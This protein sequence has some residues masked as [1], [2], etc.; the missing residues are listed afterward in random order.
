MARRRMISAEI[1]NDEEFNSLSIEAQNLFVRL[2]AVSDDFGVVPA[3]PYSMNKI[4]NT[5]PG[6]DLQKGITEIVGQKLGKIIDYEEKHFFIFKADRFDEYQ[7][8]VIKNRARSEYL[9]LSLE[10]D[11]EKIRELLGSSEKNPQHQDISHRECKDDIESVKMKDKD[12]EAK[13]SEIWLRYPDHSGKKN[14]LRHFLSS[15]ETPDDVIRIN[16][17]LDNYLRSSKVKAG[18]VKNGSTWFNEW[19]DWIAP[20]PL[21]MAGS[22]K[23]KV[24]PVVDENFSYVTIR[25]V[26]GF[27][28]LYRVS[29]VSGRSIRCVNLEK[30]CQETFDPKEVLSKAVQGKNGL[31]F[32]AKNHNH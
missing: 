6:I 5:P 31:Q 30:D 29:K 9:R 15:V 7:S 24:D 14:A 26:C 27:V 11:S 12:R 18:F 21:M 32:D 2:L 3:N 19:E 13:F 8:Y 17:A 28:Y 10:K 22:A 20:T 1:I 4:I 16:K 25:G 23:G